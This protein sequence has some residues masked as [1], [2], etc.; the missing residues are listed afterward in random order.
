MI[1]VDTGPLVALFDRDDRHHQDVR[2]YFASETSVLVTNMP[3]LSEAAYLLNFS[4]D[5]VVEC[6]EWVRAAFDIDEK[7]AADLPRI[8]EVISKYS[9]LPADFA[10]ASLVALCERLGLDRIATLDRDF[11][12]YR[13]GRGRGRPFVN[14]LRD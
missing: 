1:V 9:D 3:V 2:R 4:P 5:T 14:V 10:D 12:V 8:A 6:L 11:E 7:T 13:L